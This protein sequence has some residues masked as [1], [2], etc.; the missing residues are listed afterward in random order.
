MRIK[1][2]FQVSRPT[3]NDR[4]YRWDII[5]NELKR[6]MQ[7]RTGLPIVEHYNPD[8]SVDLRA[9]IGFGKSYEIDKD[10]NIFI[11]FEAVSKHHENRAEYYL[12]NC[13]FTIQG[14]G[15]VN[16]ETN[17]VND[18]FRLICVFPT[19]DST[20]LKAPQNLTEGN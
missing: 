15:T 18:D 7:Y 20:Y 12:K 10:G 1:L 19:R 17:E 16:T 8:G 6:V 4:I 3:V 5:E 9:L 14:F 2:N 13:D 11:E